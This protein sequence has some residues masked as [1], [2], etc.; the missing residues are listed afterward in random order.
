MDDLDQLGQRPPAEDAGRIGPE[1]VIEDEGD[2]VDAHG[3]ES[4]SRGDRNSFASE[5]R[6]WVV[7]ASLFSGIGLPGRARRPNRPGLV[8]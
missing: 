3:L 2:A 5:L 8:I 7:Y 6:K 1:A 4:S